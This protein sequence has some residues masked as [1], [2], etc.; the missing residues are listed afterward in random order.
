ML[1]FGCVMFHEYGGGW[2][3]KITKN[4]C[5]MTFVTKL[6]SVDDPIWN[7][8]KKEYEIPFP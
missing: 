6:F 3:S 2:F 4:F 7:Y 5:D 8:F 1:L